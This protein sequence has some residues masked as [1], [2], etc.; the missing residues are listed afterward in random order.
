MRR[1]ATVGMG[2]MVA[3]VLGSVAPSGALASGP[4]WA[5]CAKSLPKSTGA[6]TDKACTMA[7]SGHEGG[8]ELVDGIGKG[9]G[10]KGKSSS[11]SRFSWNVPGKGEFDLECSDLRV[12]GRPV[13][14]NKVADVVIAFSKCRTNLSGFEKSC[15]AQT[16]PLSG[17]L[18]WIDRETGSAGVDLSSEASP[19]G[20]IAEVQGCLAQVKERWTGSV[21]ANWSPV[22]TLGKLSTLSFASEGFYTEETGFIYANLPAAFEGEETEHFIVNELNSPSTGFEWTADGVRSGG[23]GATVAVKGETLMIH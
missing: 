13:A 21:I 6:Y 18:G 23:L 9:K 20:P 12:S 11:E 4:V 3:L 15:V 8:Y 2:L 22:A 17:E 1:I 16:V 19:G 5:Y 7:A 14:P 10:F